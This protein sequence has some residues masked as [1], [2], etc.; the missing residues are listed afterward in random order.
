MSRVKV[1]RQLMNYLLSILMYKASTS[2]KY[3]VTNH[4][5]KLFKIWLSVQLHCSPEFSKKL[6]WKTF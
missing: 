1:T 2:S 5:T 3:L 4:K 6:N